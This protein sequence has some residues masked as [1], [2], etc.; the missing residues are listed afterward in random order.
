MVIMFASHPIGFL[1]K[2]WAAVSTYVFSYLS[3]Q[4][5]KQALTDV[6]AV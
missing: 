4:Q 1:V 6:P 2:R 3:S 5:A